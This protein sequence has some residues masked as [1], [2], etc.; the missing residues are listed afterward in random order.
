VIGSSI[1]LEILFGIPIWL[2]SIVTVVDSLLFL[3]IHYFGVRKL[4]A[5][6]GLLIAVMAGCFF[7]NF[8]LVKPAMG[9]VAFGTLVPTVPAGCLT[10]AIGLLGAVIMPHNLHLHSSLVLSRKTTNP[11]EANFY[12]AIESAISLAISFAISFA[13]VG[14]FAHYHVGTGEAPEELNLRN[15]DDAL[16]QSFGSGARIVWAVG[17]LAAGQ[18]STM[19]GTYAGQ[20]VMEGFLDIQLPVWKRVLTTRCVAVLPALAVAFVADYDS[21]DTY[22]NVLQAIQLPFALVPLLKFTDSPLVMG[23]EFANSRKVSRFAWAA[24]SV[25]FLVNFVQLAVALIGDDHGPLEICGLA[26]GIIAYLYLLVMVVR[27]PLVRLPPCL[28]KK[29]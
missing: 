5:F 27:A 4:E 6:F 29:T 28:G 14:T 19:T 21:V 22:L 25:L 15:A 8:L 11:R 17:L 26:S 3:F 1:A 23:E 20:F 7:L 9:E 24:A 18:S 16:A 2:G 12:N 13:V 10:P